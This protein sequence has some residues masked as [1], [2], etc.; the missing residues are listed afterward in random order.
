MEMELFWGF[1]ITCINSPTGISIT[2][3]KT[4]ARVLF[5]PISFS[6]A[7]LHIHLV[8][9]MSPATKWDQARTVPDS[10]PKSSTIVSRKSAGFPTNKSIIPEGLSNVVKIQ[11]AN[12]PMNREFPCIHC[13]VLCE[14]G[15]RSMRSQNGPIHIVGIRKRIMYIVSM[16]SPSSYICQFCFLAGDTTWL[17]DIFKPRFGTIPVRYN[18]HIGTDQLSGNPTTL[19][20][21]W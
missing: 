1:S 11:T 18:S 13:L 5:N 7:F 12:G 2:P 16:Q 3:K 15:S 21:G 17:L 19:K 4:I 8:A 20:N 9:I 6:N 10:V 14:L